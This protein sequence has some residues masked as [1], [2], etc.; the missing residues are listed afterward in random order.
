VIKQVE[1]V[2][3]ARYGKSSAEI[4][5]VSSGTGGSGGA[6]R[7]AAGTG[8][9]P[10]RRGHRGS[11]GDRHGRA[12]AEDAGA[13]GG[14]APARRQRPSPEPDARPQGHRRLERRERRRDGTGGEARGDG[15]LERRHPHSRPAGVHVRRA[16]PGGF[17]GSLA[18][19]AVASSGPA[20]PPS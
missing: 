10:A 12:A 15:R 19:F 16:R 11:G 1:D 17:L 9:T 13:G 20:P 5:G 8:G 14:P 7:A 2:V 4:F 6:A 18:G 3:R